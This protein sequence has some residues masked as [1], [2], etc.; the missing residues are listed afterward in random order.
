MEPSDLSATA[1]ASE[2]TPGVRFAPRPGERIG[3][4]LLVRLLGEGTGGRVF[5]VLHEKLERRAALKLLD[6]RQAARP[7][8]R[9]R[10]FAEALSITRINHP[11]IVEVTD[12]VETDEHAGLVMELL[13]GVSLAAAMREGPLAPER[14]LPILAEVC[15]ALAAAHAAGFVHRDLKPENVFLC[16]RHGVSDFVKLLDFGVAAPRPARTST[17]MTTS[18]SSASSASS[19]GVR[20]AF[21]GTPAY[22]SPEQA[23]GAEVDHTT[24]LYAVGVMLYE[25]ACGRLPF[26]GW[27]AGEMLIQHI[28]AAVPRLPPA[29]CATPLGRSLDAIVQGC[30]AKEPLDR[31]SSAAELATKLAA[32]GRGES[33]SIVTPKTPLG[34]PR[35]LRVLALAIA[36]GL[37][38]LGGGAFLVERAVSHFHAASREAIA[39]PAPETPPPSTAASVVTL[40]FESDPA[41]AQARLPGGALLGVTPFRRAFPR[42]AEP[43]VVEL[44]LDGYAPAR[45]EV[46]TAAPRIVSATLAKVRGKKPPKAAHAAGS[47]SKRS[48]RWSSKSSSNGSSNGSW[49][50]RPPPERL[51]SEKTINPFSR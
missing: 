3:P 16:E 45:L 37:A 18:A 50:S 8:V 25:L 27:S 28:S 10:F 9:A 17:G 39:V 29:M 38:V 49:P 30:M 33:V 51:G 43:I 34:R 7:S 14:F 6:G 5:E 36:G 47:S 40:T 20:R 24:D 31:F 15:E 44:V 2:A 11:H 4:Y 21:V 42:R 48:S 26:D 23:S 12:I 46:S 41:G 1:R 22:A 19:S 35:R 32:L 13:E